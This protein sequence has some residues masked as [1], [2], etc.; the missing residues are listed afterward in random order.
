MNAFVRKFLL[1]VQSL[2]FGWFLAHRD[3]VLG[4][5]CYVPGIDVGVRTWLKS[6]V[7]VLYLNE[8]LSYFHQTCINGASGNTYRLKRIGC[9]I[10]DINVRCWKIL[11]QVKVSGAD[12]LWL[13]YLSYYW[14]WLHQ[15]YMDNASYNT[16]APDRSKSC[17]TGVSDVSYDTLMHLT[18][19]NAEYEP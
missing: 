3:E 6:L 2:L 7:L 19:L 14:S 11:E 15:S 18:S 16:H 17:M 9:W 8:Y 13:L 1:H 10:W 12:A 4:S 5:L